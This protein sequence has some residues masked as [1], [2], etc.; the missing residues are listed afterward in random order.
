MTS[1]SHRSRP[2]LCGYRRGRRAFGPQPPCLLPEPP[3]RKILAL[4]CVRG[5]SCEGSC[6]A[7]DS[8]CDLRDMI[9]ARSCR[10][11][12]DRRR[13]TRGQLVHHQS[14]DGWQ[15]HHSF[16]SSTPGRQASPFSSSVRPRAD[17]SAVCTIQSRR[18]LI[19]RLTHISVS[20][21]RMMTTPSVRSSTSLGPPRWISL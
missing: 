15:P 3:S 12:A 11:L 6:R 4:A 7:S 18:T 2:Q 9:V 13:C 8:R 14:G 5:K 10:A 19:S 21:I 17:T 1:L 20:R 16:A